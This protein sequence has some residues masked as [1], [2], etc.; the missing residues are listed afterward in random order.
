MR[1]NTNFELKLKKKCLFAEASWNI[2]KLR[3]FRKIFYL[4]YSKILDFHLFNYK[5]IHINFYYTFLFTF[6][7]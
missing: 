4:D 7:L 2:E 1:I 6:K 5:I 3:L